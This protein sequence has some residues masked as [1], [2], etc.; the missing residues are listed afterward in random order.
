M[1]T[2]A[3]KANNPE[4]LEQDQIQEREEYDRAEYKLSV[5]IS[6]LE[7]WLCILRDI[8]AHRGL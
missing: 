7:H 6:E 4:Q 2:H 3:S 1:A 5:R 8:R